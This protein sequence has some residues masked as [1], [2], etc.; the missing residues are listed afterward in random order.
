MKVG[1]QRVVVTGGAGFIGSHVMDRLVAVGA[2]AVALDDLSVGREDNLEQAI[3]G[4]AELIVGDIRDEDT[5]SEVLEGAD[6]VIHMACDN[7][8]ASL[9]NPRKTHEVNGTGTLV[10]A[11]AAVR[12]GVKR[13]VYV[14]TSESYGSAVQLPMPETHPLMP[15][16]V[17]G[18]SKA[19][20][21]LCAQA[22]MRTYGLPVTV[23]RP[24]N[25]YGPREHATGNSAEV[26]PKFVGRL[27]A[28]KP[29]VIF[30]DGSQTRDF[31]WVEETAVGIVAVTECDALVGEAV[32]VAHGEEVTIKEIYDLLCD[33]MGVDV[34]AEIAEPRPGDVAR[35]WADT[36]KA[37]EHAGY[38][39]RI[40]IR[41]G[42]ER[43]VEWATR[44]A[45]LERPA[46]ADVIRNW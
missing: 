38:E 24:F 34:E 8:R 15:T 30:G 19:Y 35:H 4:G 29:P 7:L 21:E 14:S 33:V 16:T 43:Y 20:G 42:L 39:A 10:T 23:I 12:R 46:E 18:A 2:S 11:L 6:V 22:C 5:M 37:R 27:A 3:A 41:E 13:F 26:I 25:S 17:Y 40:P 32:N 45:G 1:G 9:G 44:G 28:G 31:T 36:T